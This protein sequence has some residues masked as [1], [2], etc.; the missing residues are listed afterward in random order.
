M[1]GDRDRDKFQRILTGVWFPEQRFPQL[2]PLSEAGLKEE[3]FWRYGPEEGAKILKQALAQR[4]M[5]M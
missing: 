2:G 4:D 1:T 3:L 5:L